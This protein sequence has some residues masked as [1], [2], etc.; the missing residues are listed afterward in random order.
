M[1]GPPR[2][3]SFSI[4]KAANGSQRTD[5]W[6]SKPPLSPFVFQLERM[7]TVVGPTGAAIGITLVASLPSKVNVLAGKGMRITGGDCLRIT[8]YWFTTFG[9]PGETGKSW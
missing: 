2:D 8:T 5:W 9:L 3:W 1:N 4:A 7:S 6:M